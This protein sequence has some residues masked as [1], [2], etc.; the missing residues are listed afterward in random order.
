MHCPSS[1]RSA[2]CR[3]HASAAARW[4][5]VDEEL[6]D[7]RSRTSAAGRLLDVNE[8]PNEVRLRNDFEL[9]FQGTSAVTLLLQIKEDVFFMELD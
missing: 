9:Y 6:D 3:S 8:E 2:A 7:E 1:P 5:D 4:L